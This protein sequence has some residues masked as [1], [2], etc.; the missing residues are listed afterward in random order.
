PLAGGVAE[1]VEGGAVEPRPGVALVN[2]DMIALEFVA[3]G[4]GP[5]A[6][7]TDLAVDGLVTP[8]LLGR[9]PGING[10]S[11]GPNSPLLSM[12]C[13]RPP[14]RRRAGVG[15]PARAGGGHHGEVR[16]RSARPT[17]RD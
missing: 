13:R 12:G 17:P 1:A 5:G 8:L 7:G 3:V 16:M 4:R 2:E 11:H 9:D 6:E 14:D 15:R 10:G